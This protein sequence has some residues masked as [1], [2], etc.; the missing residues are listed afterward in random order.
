MNG[1]WKQSLTQVE[2]FLPCKRKCFRPA[3]TMPFAWNTRRLTVVY[4][5]KQEKQICFVMDA[6]LPLSQVKLFA[7]DVEKLLKAWEER[8]YKAGSQGICGCLGF[9]GWSFPAF[10]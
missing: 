9:S 1:F 2:L 10:A 7:Q 8:R 5:Y 6:A 4:R 3:M